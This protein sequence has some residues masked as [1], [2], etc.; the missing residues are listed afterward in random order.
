M[1]S[2]SVTKLHKTPNEASQFIM[3]P[4]LT[5]QN[6]SFRNSWTSLQLG[7]F[8]E[9]NIE[10]AER[11]PEAS[12]RGNALAVGRHRMQNRQ[13]RSL[14]TPLR[15]YQETNWAAQV[16]DVPSRHVAQGS[17]ALRD[18][19]RRA[20]WSA[21]DR[22]ECSAHH[23]SRWVITKIYIR[24]VVPFCQGLVTMG[25]TVRWG[26]TRRWEHDKDTQRS[27]GTYLSRMSRRSD[28]ATRDGRGRPHAPLGVEGRP[29]SKRRL[30]VPAS[31]PPPARAPR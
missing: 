29:V 2:R 4:F 5:L 17:V 28:S 21:P 14:P 9:R 22:N 18:R 16:P 12:A 15:L 8:P 1:L 30:W 10:L 23:A 26:E 25:C 20:A 11:S 7:S 6:R 3:A 24:R 27:R 19:S 13:L 31:W